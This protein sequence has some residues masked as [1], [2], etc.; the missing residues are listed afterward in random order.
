MFLV[1][2]LFV[3]AL[4]NLP[5]LTRGVWVGILTH[6][7]ILGLLWLMVRTQFLFRLVPR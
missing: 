2:V 5:V 4:A 3:V 7:V 6:A 1:N